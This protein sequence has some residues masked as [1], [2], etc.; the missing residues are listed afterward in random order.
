MLGRLLAV[1]GGHRVDMADFTAMLD[2]VCAERGW[3]WAH[4]LQPEAQ[5]WLREDL[6]GEWDAVLL[7]DIP[8]LHM[9]RG[10]MPEPFGPSAGEAA[11]LLGLL[12][13]GQGLVVTHHALA[14]WPLWDAWANA[15]GGRYL[16]APGTL[17]GVEM[18]AS[19]YRM[20]VHHVDVLA[21]QHPVC[22][23]VEG[24]EVDDEL[25]LCPVHEE[26][27]Q[28][29]L[30]TTASMDP[31]L[32]I[33]TVRVL[34]EGHEH[35]CLPG[36]PGSRLVGWAKAAL[37]SPLVYLQPGHGPET[38]RHPMYR[39]LLGNAIEWVASADAHAWARANPAEVE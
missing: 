32:F 18:P 31:T 34:T 5:R 2:A 4:A 9:A 28:P 39:R 3:V 13:A 12:R 25:Y 19:G 30:A 37:N 23:G 15:I 8:G 1:T 14:A 36:P 33:D 16:Y 29:L 11:A 10:R 20:A 26:D 17:R 7:H 35:A 21:P 27:V 38:M 22:T 24:F 6:A